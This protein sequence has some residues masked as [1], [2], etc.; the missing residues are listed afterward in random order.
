MIYPINAGSIPAVAD[1]MSGI[2][3][4]WWDLEGASQQLSDVGLLAK[5]VGWYIGEEEGKPQG[6]LLCA[7]YPG[8]SCLSIENL[9]Y[10][11]DGHF[12]MEEPLE[13]LL[14]HAETHAKQQGFRMMKYIIS[15]IGLSCHG[16]PLGDYGD[17][18]RKLRSNGREHF[19]YF[20]RCGFTPAG[21]LPNCYGEN[22]HGIL[23]IKTMV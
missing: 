10:A 21:F 2:K 15:S 18:L 5:L 14:A 23:M 11:Q 12:V 3:P 19:D 22:W 20:V 9:G 1:L 8:Y 17:E 16:R 4:D 7:E 13:P 6:W